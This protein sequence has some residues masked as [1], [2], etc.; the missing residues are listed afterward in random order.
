MSSSTVAS[1]RG[2]NIQAVSRSS[3]LGSEVDRLESAPDSS[4]GTTRPTTPA[5]EGST[6]AGDQQDTESSADQASDPKLA[7]NSKDAA[8][9]ENEP[10]LDGPDPIPLPSSSV[11]DSP[12]HLNTTVS[13]DASSTSEQSELAPHRRSGSTRG[14]SQ[15]AARSISE[16]YSLTSTR[17][18]LR[19]GSSGP[20]EAEATQ[21]GA[22]TPTN[23][24]TKSKKQRLIK[25]DD[26]RARRSPSVASVGPSTTTPVA[27]RGQKDPAPEAPAGMMMVDGALRIIPGIQG[28]LVPPESAHTTSASLNSRMEDKGAS[29]NDFCEVCG[30]NGRFLCCDGCPRSFH[31]F[32][33][34]PPL[35]IDEMPVSNA[36]G[37]VQP[38]LLRSR[39]GKGK[40]KASTRRQTSPES[41]DG[42]S[43]EEMWF[44]NVCV[45]ERVSILILDQSAQPEHK[46]RCR[47]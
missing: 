47:F 7:T 27:A 30:G 45:A 15:Q 8:S 14:A 46:Y 11:S 21:S 23:P 10:L 22:S 38:S 20:N 40:A 28:A 18:Q 2:E 5:A 41:V 43:P 36:A 26:E 17:G 13:A 19:S 16:A 44:C 25:D 42:L 4:P 39:G 9:I 12:K 37:L 32:C 1:V 35:D 24:S 33:M 34:N 3:P 31:F 29:N 6:S